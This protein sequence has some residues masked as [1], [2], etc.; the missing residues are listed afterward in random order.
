[1][2]KE[3]KDY[4]EITLNSLLGNAIYNKKNWTVVNL[5]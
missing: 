3:T 5:V 1:M 4:Q 2:P